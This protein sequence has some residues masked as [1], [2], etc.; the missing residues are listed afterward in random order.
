MAPGKIKD[1]LRVALMEARKPEMGK[2]NRLRR[3]FEFSSTHLA[4]RI[5][6]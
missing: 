2:R 1:D 4:L 6:I 5:I 3:E